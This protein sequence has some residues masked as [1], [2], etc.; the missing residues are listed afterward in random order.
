MAYVTAIVMLALIE[1]LAFGGLVGAQRG[2]RSVPAPATTGDEIFER[3]FRAHQNTLEQLVIFVPAIYAS[4]YYASALFAAIA[5]VVFL[6]ARAMYF[7]AYTREPGSRGPGAVITMLAN[8]AL[9]LS[10]L[11][12]ALASL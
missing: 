1:Y 7:R 5:G 10:A 12:G 4:A 11:I 3:Y 6:I 8:A 2:K 9:I